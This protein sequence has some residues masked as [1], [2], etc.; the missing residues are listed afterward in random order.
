MNYFYCFPVS[1]H[2]FILQSI[3]EISQFIRPQYVEIVQVTNEQPHYNWKWNHEV[4]KTENKRQFIISDSQ[5]AF[6]VLDPKFCENRE[7]NGATT[8]V[9]TILF[10][11]RIKC[12]WEADLTKST[13]VVGG[14]AYL[15]RQRYYSFSWCSQLQSKPKSCRRNASSS[16]KKHKDFWQRSTFKVECILTDRL[17]IVFFFSQFGNEIASVPIDIWG[18]V[19]EIFK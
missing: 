2:R 6:S 10:S 5:M 7:G 3:C 11:V 14:S 15:D 8:S 18:L 17:A 9:F 19:K 16:V 1:L 12:S 4:T 13:S